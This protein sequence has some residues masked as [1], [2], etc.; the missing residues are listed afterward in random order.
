MSMKVFDTLVNMPSAQHDAQRSPFPG[1]VILSAGSPSLDW[2]HAVEAAAARLEE[3]WTRSGATGHTMVYG[4]A[5]ELAATLCAYGMMG[6]EIEHMHDHAEV[7]P[8]FPRT[9]K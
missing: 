7:S 2:G 6:A 1:P 9:A 5:E 4:L 3:S 8:H